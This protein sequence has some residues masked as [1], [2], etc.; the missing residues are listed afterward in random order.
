M[1]FF[2]GKLNRRLRTKK[3]FS[4]ILPGS[5]E[6]EGVSNRLCGCYLLFLA[7]FRFLRRC[8][9]LFTVWHRNWFW[10]LWFFYLGSY[11][12]PN[13]WTSVSR[14]WFSRYMYSPHC[15]RNY[16]DKDTSIKSNLTFASVDTFILRADYR[17]VFPGSDVGRD[18]VRIKSNKTYK[19]HV[20]VWVG[21]YDMNFRRWIDWFRLL[22]DSIFVICRKDVGMCK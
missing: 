18:S 5:G 13:S 20:A 4:P 17:K 2:L 21:R 3:V 7:F 16:V 11:C 1:W 6:D 19:R 8:I 14:T 15:H 9:W 12:W 22:I 10:F